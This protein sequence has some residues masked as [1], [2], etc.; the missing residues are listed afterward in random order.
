MAKV[1]RTQS[2]LRM[3]HGGLVDS[4]GRVEDDSGFQKWQGAPFE[5]FRHLVDVLQTQQRDQ[6]SAALLDTAGKK[7]RRYSLGVRPCHLRNPREKLP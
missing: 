2:G 3:S 4:G 7:H 6:L 1:G 5:L